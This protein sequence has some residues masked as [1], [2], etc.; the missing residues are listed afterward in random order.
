MQERTDLDCAKAGGRVGLGR[1]RR[2]KHSEGTHGLQL[3]P[4]PGVSEEGPPLGLLR[5][6]CDLSP[7]GEDF[8]AVREAQ[9]RKKKPLA[10]RE[11]QRTGALPVRR[12]LA[13]L[14]PS[15]RGQP[16]YLPEVAIDPSK[17][18]HS[19]STQFD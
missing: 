2:H 18:P 10:E 19:P 8:G 9:A 13:T 4:T 14:A 7:G 3:H 5:M 12:P 16:R 11:T 1:I 15:Y 6:D 17:G